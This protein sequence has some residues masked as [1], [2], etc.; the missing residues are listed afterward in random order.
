MTIAWEASVAQMKRIW[1]TLAEGCQ[2]KRGMSMKFSLLSLN[3]HTYQ[4][5]NHYTLCQ[6]IIAH[7][8]EVHIIAEAIIQQNVDIICF[9]EVGEDKNNLITH[10]YGRAPSNMAFRIYQQLQNCGQHWYFFQ[11][12]SHI[13]YEHW[14]EGMAVLSRYPM[15]HNYSTYI[16]K[17][18]SKDD[19]MSRNVIMTCVDVSNFGLLHIAN[20]HLNWWHCGFKEEFDNLRYAIEARAHLGARGGLICGDFNAPAGGEAYQYVVQ[21]AEYIDQWYE[22]SP[23]NFFEPTHQKHIDGWM[24]ANPQRIDYIFKH[25]GSSFKIK[26]LKLIFNHHFYPLVS[27]HYGYIAQFDSNK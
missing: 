19:Y 24:Q 6:T 26:S 7:E 22:I 14:R 21:N 20:V 17:N 16:S 5:Y 11:D 3:L 25:V 23:P 8:Q 12:W 13:G 10:P 15:H 27:D 18:Q 9:Q 1:A 2:E 4:Q